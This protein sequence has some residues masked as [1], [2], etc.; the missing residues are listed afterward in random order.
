MESKLDTGEVMKIID[1][2]STL[3]I[4]DKSNKTLL[5]EIKAPDNSVFYTFSSHTTYGECPIISYLPEHS[6]NGWQ[7]WFYRIDI[8]EKTMEQINPWK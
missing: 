4:Y 1:E 3:Q 8:N 7:D 2:G 6:I 5:F